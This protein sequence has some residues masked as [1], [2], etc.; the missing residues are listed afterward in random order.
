M[1]YRKL[2]IFKEELDWI[3][4]PNLKQF[5]QKAVSILPDY[6]FEVAASSTG[7]YHSKTCLGSG[8]LVRHTKAALIIAHDLFR[9]DHIFKF[10]DCEKDCILIALMLHD[11]WKHGDNSSHFTTFDHP[12]VAAEHVAE[13]LREEDENLKVKHECASIIL[14]C[15]RAHMGK[16]NTSNRSSVVLPVPSNACEC[17]VSLCDYMASRSY[18]LYEFENPYEPFNYKADVS[19]TLMPQIEMLCDICQKAI[20]DGKDRDILYSIIRKHNNGSTNPFKI[21]DEDSLRIIQEGV[22]AYAFG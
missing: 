15:I 22:N 18:L 10:T 4:D 2:E 6:F 17:F 11:G 3:K 21:P 9:C 14:G 1:A 12:L 16:W 5:A 8:G 7:K 20:A 13:L 19:E